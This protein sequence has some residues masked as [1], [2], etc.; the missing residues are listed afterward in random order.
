MVGEALAELSPRFSRL[1]AKVGRPSIG[2]REAAKQ[3]AGQ[4]AEDLDLRLRAPRAF[5]DQLVRARSFR[6][7]TR[8]TPASGNY[9]GALIPG[10]NDRRHGIGVGLLL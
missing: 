8:F 2:L 3:R 5:W 7:T 1:Y 4:L 9:S 10:E 6:I